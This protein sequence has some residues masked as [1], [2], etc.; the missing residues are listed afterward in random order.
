M[1]Q[2]NISGENPL[3]LDRNKVIGDFGHVLITIGWILDTNDL[4]QL[5]SKPLHCLFEFLVS[6]GNGVSFSSL[7][8]IVAKSEHKSWILRLPMQTLSTTQLG[9]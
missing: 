4:L 3:P 9:S 5:F 8:M 7:L 1:L 2:E 6:L